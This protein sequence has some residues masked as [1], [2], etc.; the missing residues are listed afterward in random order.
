MRTEKITI[1]MNEI[2]MNTIEQVFFKVQ[3]TS[4]HKKMQPI[5]LRIWRNIIEE[6]TI[7]KQQNSSKNKNIIG[8]NIK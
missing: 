7:V 4:Q 2:R 8:E 3:N 5:L 1:D 6:Y